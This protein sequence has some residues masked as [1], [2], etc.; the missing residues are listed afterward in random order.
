MKA[1]RTDIV[2][3]AFGLAFLGLSAWWLLA[4]IL[5]LALP[6]VGWFLAGALILIGLLG[7]VG[8]LRSGRHTGPEPAEST[9]SAP[10]EAGTPATSTPAGDEA[11]EWATDAVTDAPLAAREDRPFDEEP[12]WSPGA[13]E[14]RSEPVT[15]ELSPVEPA[16]PDRA[17]PATRELP[18]AEERYD[19][20]RELPAAEERTD[21]TRE[22]P[23]AEE[24]D[25]TAGPATRELPAVDEAADRPGGGPRTG[26]DGPG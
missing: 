26:G 16:L 17:E 14:V 1:H 8:A 3:F 6:P 15:R 19:T 18:A 4:R 5:G 13:P 22:L 11:D 12:R 2:S 9:V 24:R 10:Y 7:L 23:A 21:A 25:G 20:T